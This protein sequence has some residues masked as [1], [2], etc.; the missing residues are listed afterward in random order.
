V[1]VRPNPVHAEG[2]WVVATGNPFFLALDG[3]SVCTLGIV[4]GLDRILGGGFL[5]GKAIQH[6]AEVNPGNSGGPLWN[7][8]G[9]FIGINGM[10]ASQQTQGS[11]PHNTGAS[12][13]IPA[14]QVASFL[15][16]LIDKRDAQAA[17]LPVQYETATDKK[18]NPSGARVTKVEGGPRDTKWLQLEDVIT[19]IVVGN[20]S[21]DIR[22][23]SDLTNVLSLVQAGASVRI[24]Y[25]RGTRFGQ[26][27]GTLTAQ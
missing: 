26:W 27:D 13:S 17:R 2:S 19:R 5:Y 15:A 10:I 21:N 8:R 1:P 9:D 24:V 3:Q 18:G 11:G 12:F 23:A 6:D 4:S 14:E 25:R 16:A 20:R 22:T 7:L